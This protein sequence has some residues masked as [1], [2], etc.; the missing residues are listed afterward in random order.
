MR[1]E[2]AGVEH[3]AAIA[4]LN[5]YV[6]A[7]HVD[8]EPDQFRDLTPEEAEPAFASMLRDRDP[9]AFVAANDDRWVGYIWAEEVQRPENPFTKPFRTL[10][11]HHIAVT[12]EARDSGVGRALVDAVA[13]EARRR[14][15]ASLAL[16]HWSFN[17]GA[18]RFFQALGFEVFNVRMRR[19]L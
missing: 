11:I 6:H 17:E 8:A 5:Q 15:V 18:S 4:A 16:D 10:Y 13:D 19:E 14:G 1:I 12:P 3:A 7:L 2:R 9:V